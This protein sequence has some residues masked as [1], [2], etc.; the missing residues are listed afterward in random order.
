M[1]ELQVSLCSIPGGKGR[2]RNVFLIKLRAICIL[3][4]V[5]EEVSGLFILQASTYAKPQQDFNAATLHRL[6]NI[7]PLHKVK[8]RVGY[9]DDDDSDDAEDAMKKKGSMGRTLTYPLRTS[10]LTTGTLLKKPTLRL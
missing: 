3:S 4:R 2:V 10:I 8:R 6:R 7:S 9:G 1:V 5:V